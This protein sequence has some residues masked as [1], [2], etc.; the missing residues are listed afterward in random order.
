MMAKVKKQSKYLVEA[1]G[2]DTSVSPDQLLKT[3]MQKYL[4]VNVIARRARELNRGAKALV[5]LPPEAS[6]TTE[7]AMEEVKQGKLL[8]ERKESSKILVSLIQNE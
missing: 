4:L 1:K 6:T 7:I 3:R 5:E 8:L 2:P